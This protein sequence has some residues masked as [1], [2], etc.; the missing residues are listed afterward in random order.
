MKTR[1]L[2]IATATIALA[3]TAG[4]AWAGDELITFTETFDHGSNEGNWTFGIPQIEVFPD[5]GGNPDWWLHSTCEGLNCLDTFAPQPRTTPMG[6]E[7]EFTGNY[8]ERGVSHIGID[9]QTIHVDFGA[10]DRPLTVILINDNGNPDNFADNW[11]AYYIG[12]ENIPLV[13]EGWKSFDFDIPSDSQELPPGWQFIT[14]GGDAPEPD[15]NTLITDVSQLRFFYGDPELF[16]I[17]QQWELGMDNPRITDL[18]C[19]IL[20]DL[21]CDQAVDTKDLFIL[22]AAWGPCDDPDECPAD[23]DGSGEVDTEDLFIL[24]ANWG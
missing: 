11:G 18:A 3:A 7:N 20:G 10:G 13:G 8:R 9:L 19:P 15:W 1:N 16:F 22:L 21:N 4:S 5:R 24:L 2:M 17:F 14:Y 12:P 23:L 6:A